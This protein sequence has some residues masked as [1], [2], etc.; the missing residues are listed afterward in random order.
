[1]NALN[2]I[3][4]FLILSL[5]R[6]LAKI[7]NEDSWQLLHAT[8]CGAMLKSTDAWDQAT[9][10]MILPTVDFFEMFNNSS[11][12][13]DVLLVDVDKLSWILLVNQVA[14]LRKINAD[15]PVYAVAYDSETCAH[16]S[17]WGISC[18]YNADWV[19]ALR[20]AYVHFTNNRRSFNEMHAVMMGRM[21]TSM[22]MLCAGIN[23]FLTDTDLVFFRNPLDYAFRAV[24]IMVTATPIDAENSRWGGKFFTSQPA[25]YFTL[26]N[27]VVFFRSSS[28]MCNFLVSL[29]ASSANSLRSGPDWEKGFLQTTFNG[30]MNDHKLILSPCRYS[31][32]LIDCLFFC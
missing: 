23:V 18:Y 4:C 12:P 32:N 22:A 3:V 14:G 8:Q 9:I 1:M 27:G 25:Q 2:V 5:K 21:V 7:A 10:K 28:R 19:E 30:L 11:M 15:I 17:S 26:N 13:I 29:A 31:H 6:C 24:D 20:S 16:L